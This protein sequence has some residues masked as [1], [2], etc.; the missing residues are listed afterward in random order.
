MSSLKKV[1]SGRVTA[2]LGG[3]SNP[4]EHGRRV[5][6]QFGPEYRTEAFAWLEREHCLVVF[7]DKGTRAWWPPS[8]R[9]AGSKAE[10]EEVLFEDYLQEWMKHRKRNGNCVLR[11]ATKRNLKADIAHFL[12]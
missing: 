11:G 5:G 6:R 12:P 4:L 7:H 8:G 9:N 2:W 3:Y 10:D 1:G